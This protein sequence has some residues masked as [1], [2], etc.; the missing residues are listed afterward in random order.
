MR[1]RFLISGIVLF[2]LAPVG[3]KSNEH[4]GGADVH[5]MYLPNEIPWKDA[6]SSLLPGAKMAVLDGDPTKDGPFCMRLKFPDGYSVMPHWH[7]RTE[8]VT[9]IQGTL[10]IGFGDTF[11]KDRTHA[12]PSGT[13]GYWTPGVRHYAWMGGETILQLNGIGPWQ[14]IYVNSAD[15][16]RKK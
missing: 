3:C 5:R 6:S 1:H 13:Y 9:V 7:P 14:I 8:R 11:D 4:P 15:D 12:L 2:V 10:N 16:P